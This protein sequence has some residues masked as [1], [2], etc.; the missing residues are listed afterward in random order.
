MQ[1]DL[2]IAGAIGVVVIGRN[3]GDRLKRCLA[4]VCAIAERVVYVDSGSS[5]GSVEIARA[6]HAVAVEL[7]MRTPFTAARARNEGCRK[8]LEIHSTLD[9]VFFV[10]G[11]CEVVEG[12]LGAAGSFLDQHG[13]IAVVSGYLRERH[14]QE[15]IYN[16]LCDIEWQDC[17]LGDT[18]V[19]GGIAMV[20]VRAFQEVK[21][22]RPDLICGGRT[23]DVRSS[24]QSWLAHLAN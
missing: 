4:S 11:D 19:C 2:G 20:R 9:Y 5:D 12:W 8:L 1:P 10:D 23:R 7:D 18:N 24:A 14:P 15:S 22:Y 6:S 13:D 16:M 3:E 21:G 17:P